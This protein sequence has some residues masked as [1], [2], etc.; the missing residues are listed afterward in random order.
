MFGN[1]RIFETDLAIK[2][3]YQLFHFLKTGRAFVQP[4]FLATATNSSILNIMYEHIPSG[5]F[6]KNT[7]KI[8][9]CELALPLDFQYKN[10]ELK[11]A[12]HA[13]FPINIIP[14]ENLKPFLY[15]T[16]ALS[17][18]IFLNKK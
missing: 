7:F 12:A 10:F 15:Y 4:E 5:N 17:H 1:S 18:N 13:A 8:V 2:G 16:F 6:N 14:N 11:L 9:D 3:N